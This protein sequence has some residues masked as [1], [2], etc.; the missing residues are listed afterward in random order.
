MA[1]PAFES[2]KVPDRNDST[3]KQIDNIVQTDASGVSVHRQAVALGDAIDH[4]V[5]ARVTTGPSLVSDPAVIVRSSAERKQLN[6]AEA[7]LLEMRKQTD[8][9][10]FILQALDPQSTVSLDDLGKEN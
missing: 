4:G 5:V 6:T 2:I 7:L 3:A 8:L 9:L 1:D 10:F